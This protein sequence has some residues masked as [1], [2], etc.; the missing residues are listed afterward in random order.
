MNVH[1]VD[2][3]GQYYKIKDE[4]DRNIILKYLD[5]QLTPKSKGNLYRLF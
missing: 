1:M 3:M 5:F 2:L 4:I